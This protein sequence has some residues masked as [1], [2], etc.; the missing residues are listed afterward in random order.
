MTS[1]VCAKHWQQFTEV[2]TK[3]APPGM[4]EATMQQT[5]SKKK[6]SKPQTR[7]NSSVEPQRKCSG[8]EAQKKKHSSDSSTE[9]LNKRQM[10][11]KNSDGSSESPPQNKTKK[12]QQEVMSSTE[13]ESGTETEEDCIWPRRRHQNPT[14]WQRCWQIQAPRTKRQ[15]VFVQEN[16]QRS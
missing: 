11:R 7:G 1:V 16:R 4:D 14:S 6:P 2:R 12:R 15:Q 3:K 9:K 10:V 13:E 5:F 8:K